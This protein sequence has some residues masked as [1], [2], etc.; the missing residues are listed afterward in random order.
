MSEFCCRL[1]VPS[2]TGWGE[3]PLCICVK[4]GDISNVPFNAAPPVGVWACWDSCTHLTDM[5]NKQTNKHLDQFHFP[6]YFSDI[7]SFLLKLMYSSI[8]TCT[9]FRVFSLQ[10]EYTHYPK[11]GF[12]L[13]QYSMFGSRNLYFCAPLLFRYVQHTSKQSGIKCYFTAL[14]ANQMNWGWALWQSTVFV[15]TLLN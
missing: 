5:K 6:R 1:V 11:S 13:N 7:V 12:S 10:D 15:N 14:Y 4:E 9:H 2:I 8:H 3:R